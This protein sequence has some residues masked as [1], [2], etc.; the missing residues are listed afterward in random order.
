M[1]AG[2]QNKY[3]NKP[4]TAE[5]K[6]ISK[7]DLTLLRLELLIVLMASLSNIFILGKQTFVTYVVW[8]WLGCAPCYRLLVM[9]APR[10]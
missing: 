4:W 8:V 6:N 5:K 10:K 7:L 2:N 1:L 9:L 3:I